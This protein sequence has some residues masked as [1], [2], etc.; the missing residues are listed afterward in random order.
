MLTF[1][2]SECGELLRD[3]DAPLVGYIVQSKV[4]YGKRRYVKTV[5]YQRTAGGFVHYDVIAKHPTLY[6]TYGKASAAFMR[7]VRTRRGRH[8]YEIT[9]VYAWAQ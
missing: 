6:S 8:R 1:K 3:E 2:C 7:A 4:G 5:S 9:P